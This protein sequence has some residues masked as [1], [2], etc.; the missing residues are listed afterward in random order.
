MLERRSFLRGLA[1]LPLVATSAPAM[2]SLHGETDLDLRDLG[3]AFTKA[4]ARLDATSARLDEAC[5]RLGELPAAPIELR[6]H[7]QDF[8]LL[9]TT[10]TRRYDG[11]AWH[12]E[13]EEIDKLRA[14]ELTDGEGY[15][16]GISRPC[17]EGRRR[18]DIIVDTWD[19]WQAA[20]K[21]AKDASGYTV[22]GTEYDAADAEHEALRISIIN[23]R[24][25]DP[26]V[27]ALKIRVLLWSSGSRDYLDR[28]LARKLADAG[29]Y[30]DA[31]LISIARDA[32]WPIAPEVTA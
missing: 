24:S 8:W 11:S 3:T 2:A 26:A 6:W 23:L 1:G 27:L 16:P 29:P 31:V 15:R 22:A 13:P 19:R 21:D 4:T 7:T 9:H 10:A 14:L 32:V 5:E 12:T 28:H 17:V 20:I 30:A 25:S 18:R